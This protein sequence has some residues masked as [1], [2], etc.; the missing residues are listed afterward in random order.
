VKK[1]NI[2]YTKNHLSELLNCVREG[3][4]VL[5]VDRK[6]PIAR[7]EPVDILGTPDAWHRKLVSEGAVRPPRLQ[8]DADALDALPLPVPGTR[9]GDILEAL[10]EERREGR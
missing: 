8:P 9:K 5:I 1:S 2:S 10:L 7:L 3:E 4:S 6:T